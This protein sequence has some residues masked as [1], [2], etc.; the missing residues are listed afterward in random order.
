MSISGYITNDLSA[1][2]ESGRELPVSELTL[3]ALADHYQV[4]FTP[5][6]TAVNRLVEDGLLE[7][8]PNRR[9]V[10]T[11]P[12]DHSSKP[13]RSRRA[14]PHPQRDSYRIIADDLMQL[15]LQGQSVFLREEVTAEKY[16]ISRSAIRNILHRLAGEGILDHSTSWVEAASLSAGRSDVV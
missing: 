2:L 12:L 16:G 6:R 5:V 13:S 10:A 3:T 14:V 9:L 4:S 11:K 8:Q 1:R 15:S 7:K